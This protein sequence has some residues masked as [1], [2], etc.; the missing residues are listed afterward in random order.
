[1]YNE[2]FVWPQVWN[3]PLNV[4]GEGY[5][6]WDVNFAFGANV[7]MDQGR[8]EPKFRLRAHHFALHLLPEPAIEMRGK[9]PLGD[10]NLAIY[11]RYR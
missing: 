11:A 2:T 6:P 10:T 4:V 5:N 9:W 8:V 1:M 7:V 3:M